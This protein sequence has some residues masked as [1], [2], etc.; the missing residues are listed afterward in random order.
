MQ[1]VAKLEKIEKDP[2]FRALIEHA[3]FERVARALI[4]GPIVI[5]RAVLFN[6]PP[7]GGTVLP[8]HQDGG[9]FWGLDQDPFLQ[10]WVALD[11]APIGSGCL[12]FVPKTHHKGLA[13]PLGGLIPEAVI[14]AAGAREKSVLVPAKAGEAI[15]VHNHVWHG[16]GVNETDLPRRGVSICYMSAERRCMRKRRAPREFVSVFEGRGVDP[17]AITMETVD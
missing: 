8:F 1:D 12:E 14:E 17:S 13:T 15:L 11:D 7:H 3:T 16:S 2:L 10:I 4:E 9:S 5:Y 6:K